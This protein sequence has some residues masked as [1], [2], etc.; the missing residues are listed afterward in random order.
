MAGGGF[1]SKH[2]RGAFPR[3]GNGAGGGSVGEKIVILDFDK[4]RASTGDITLASGSWSD[5]DKIEV[6]MG[7]TNDGSVRDYDSVDSEVVKQN[8]TGWEIQM[9]SYTG[10]AEYGMEITA[11]GANTAHWRKTR[12]SATVFPLLVI[13]RKAG[14]SSGGSG[15]GAVESVNGHVGK[16]T[17]GASDV[18]AYTRGESDNN[19][20]PKRATGT[21]GQADDPTTK[22]EGD[23]YVT[24]KFT[25]APALPVGVSY[26][27]PLRIDLDFDG[28]NNGGLIT[29]YTDAGLFYKIKLAGGW[30]TEWRNTL[31]SLTSFSYTWSS[32]GNTKYPVPQ[33]QINVVAHDPIPNN[34]PFGN[35]KLLLSKETIDAGIASID[36]ATGA[37]TP[38]KSG[39]VHLMGVAPNGANTGWFHIWVA[40]AGQGNT[41]PTTSSGVPA[42]LDGEK[43]P[44]QIRAGARLFSAPT[45]DL[46]YQEE[47]KRLEKR[48]SDLEA[49]QHGGAPR[50]DK[51]AAFDPATVAL[52]AGYADNWQDAI[53]V[54]THKTGSPIQI[55]K[56][57]DDPHKAVVMMSP[58]AATHVKGITLDGGLA[59]K[60][61]S[62]T[63][64]IVGKQY[65]AFISPYAL[66]KHPIDIGIEWSK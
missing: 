19:F 37:V 23:Y 14:S 26:I 20:E 33:E 8:P 11:T 65:T 31:P 39:W 29:Y 25:N 34:A 10:G 12:G 47:I 60:W 43:G 61:E 36:P 58:E 42:N 49:Q 52:T 45:P 50:P 4:D 28:S 17:L 7:I 48:V 13:G 27:A 53:H 46:N 44:L 41:D 30:E 32:A 22:P 15:G 35:L 16:V 63:V 64:T 54:S 59:A 56:V 24:E 1:E 9:T 6:T 18:G 40:Q 3:V 2:T 51:P 38:L 21:I 57:S 66:T 55:T 5:F 62:H